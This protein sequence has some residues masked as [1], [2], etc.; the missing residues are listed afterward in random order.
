MADAGHLGT[1]CKKTADTRGLGHPKVNSDAVFYVA[2]AGRKP[3]LYKYGL[4][5]KEH[6]FASP[7]AFARQP[8]SACV[9]A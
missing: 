1:V 5:I 4:G 2:I 3:L 9:H 6:V 7:F 8:E